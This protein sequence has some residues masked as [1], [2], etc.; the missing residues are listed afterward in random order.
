MGPGGVLLSPEPGGG[1]IV[2]LQ[3]PTGRSAGI[4]CVCGPPTPIP[5][6]SGDISVSA[7]HTCPLPAS[8]NAAAPTP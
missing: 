5:P 1:T 3:I 7:L 8:K 4:L 6:P 2:N